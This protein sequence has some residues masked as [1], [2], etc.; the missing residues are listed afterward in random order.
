MKEKN[1]RMTDGDGV[2]WYRIVGLS[3]RLEVSDQT[4]RNW[5][6]QGLVIRTED[7]EGHPWVRLADGVVKG[8]GKHKLCKYGR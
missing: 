4:I 7:A 3:K 2:E 8:G 5:I 1:Y 6:D